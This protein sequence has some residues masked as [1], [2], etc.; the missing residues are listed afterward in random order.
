V[1]GNNKLTS[2]FFS[3]FLIQKS[4]KIKAPLGNFGD[5][6]FFRVISQILDINPIKRSLIFIG[7]EDTISK[8]KVSP[9]S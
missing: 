3:V 5:Y 4:K 2:Q 9:D 1:L 8:K 6:T 7:D